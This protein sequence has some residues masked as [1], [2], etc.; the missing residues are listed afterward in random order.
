MTK[1]RWLQERRSDPY[2]RKAK[3]MG[4]PSRAA[5]KLMDI[6]KRYRVVR[7]G[8]FVLDLGAAPGGMTAVASEYVGEKGLVVAVDRE[9]V[10]VRD[11]KNVVCVNADVFAYNLHGVIMKASGNRMFDTIISDLSPRH[12]G[13]YDLLAV[14]QL[15]LLERTLEIASALLKRRGN[16]VVKAFEHPTL[17]QIENRMRRMFFQYY[18]YV[19]RASKKRSSEIFLIGLGYRGF[20]R[21]REASRGRV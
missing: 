12:S 4:L 16:L 10:K 2:W 17:R 7:E 3:E 8:G 14:Q 21:P 18:R 9:E 1:E 6:Q 15:D 19:P 11:R 20:Y 5:F 13:D